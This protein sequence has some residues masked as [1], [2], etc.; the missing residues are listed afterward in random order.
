MQQC[1][2]LLDNWATDSTYIVRKMLL[3][4]GCPD[5]PPDQWLNIVKGY[6]VDLAKV[7]EAHYSSDVDTKQSQDLGDLFQISI[8][9]P[10]QSKAIKIHGDWDIAF[11]KTIQAIFYALPGRNSE[12]VAY[13]V[14]ISALFASIT[15]SFHSRVIDL[16]KAIR[17]QATNQK[18]LCLSEFARFDNL[19]TIYLTSFGVGSSA[20]EEEQGSR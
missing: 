10:K 16:D 13:Q 12:Y 7:L 6:A 15:P 17:L 1:L 20:R 19:R 14:Y 2:N 5:F 9:V 18:H 8:Q 3:S 4:L 11:E